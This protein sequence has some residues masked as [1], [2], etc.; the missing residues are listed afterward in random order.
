MA[1]GKER[2]RWLGH[3]SPPSAAL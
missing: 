3:S 1:V 2:K